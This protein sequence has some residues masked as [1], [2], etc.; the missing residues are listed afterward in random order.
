MELTSTYTPHRSSKPIDKV[1]RFG[2]AEVG[3]LG[4]LSYKNKSE[5]SVDHLYQ[6][7]LSE[8]KCKRIAAEFDWAAFGA[9]VV[10]ERPDGTLAVTDGQHRL[11]GAMLRS[12]ID[13]VPCIIFEGDGRLKSEAIDFLTINKNRKPLSGLETFKAMVVS[14]DPEAEKINQMI[15]SAGLQLSNTKSPKSISCIK[16]ISDRM[17]DDSK[18]MQRIWP[19]AIK[20]TEGHGIEKKIIDAM[21]YAE[22]FLTDDKGNDRSLLEPE[23][24]KKLF[25]I[26]YELVM[27]SIFAAAIYRGRSNGAALAEGLINAL[28]HRRRN[29][30]QLKGY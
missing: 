16:T 5:L 2:W 4:K 22:R 24:R 19:L 3:K 9:L 12:D 25:E 26:G 1:K 18:V 8:K 14:N 21:H 6:R 7:P 27:K 29:K 10:V 20:F 30:L 23:I 15:E 17:K 28:N 13:L 11:G